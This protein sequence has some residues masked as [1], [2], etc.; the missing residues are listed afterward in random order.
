MKRNNNKKIIK[1]NNKFNIKLSFLSYIIVLLQ[2]TLFYHKKILC[3]DIYL[4]IYH[5]KIQKKVNDSYNA[6]N[7]SLQIFIV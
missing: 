4:S 2:N 3:F 7:N 5:K 1:R 6:I